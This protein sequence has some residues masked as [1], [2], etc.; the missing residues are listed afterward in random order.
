MARI[1]E[2]MDLKEKIFAH[3]AQAAFLDWDALR[4]MHKI[5]GRNGQE[6]IDLIDAPSRDPQLAIELFQNTGPRTIANDFY[7]EIFR[8]VHNFVA[9]AVTL[10]DHT[11]NHL[12]PYDGTDFVTEYEMRKATVVVPVTAFV[13]RLRSYVLHH[14]LPILGINTSFE[15]DGREG[16]QSTTVLDTS[17]LLEWEDW[18]AGARA[19][20]ESSPASLVLRSVITDYLDVIDDLYKWLFDQF[21]L[22]HS[23]DL[24]EWRSMRTRYNELIRPILG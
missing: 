8:L 7:D 24:A 14:K 23:S 18:T 20:L 2:I 22:L 13:V 4:R 6:L 5:C 1:E 3:P 16:I 12:K 15:G 9:S 17:K 21:E 19:F 11:R 10:V